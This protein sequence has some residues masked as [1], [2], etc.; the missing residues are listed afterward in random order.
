MLYLDWYYLVLV[1]PMI[2]VSLIAQSSV[3][4]NY[5]RFSKIANS[6]GLTGFEAAQRVLSYYGITNVRIEPV[7]GE[8]SDH[9]D[10]RSN[11]IRLSEGV[12]NT[13]SVSAV[14]IA[15]HEAGHASQHA[16][17][18]TPIKI[19]DSII[20]VCNIG[21]KLGIPLALAGYVFGFEPL[22]IIGILLYSLVFV[23]QLITLP[24]EF[25]ASSRALAVIEETG[26]LS[27]NEHKGAKKV[28]KAA[29]MTYVADAAT[30]L[31]NILRLILRM[32]RRS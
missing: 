3:K 2:I 17:G 22:I 1:V 24:V 15:C 13:A 11:V 31:A 14:C 8:L 5:R 16:E 20:P 29:A 6:K 32:R 9:F 27:E 18:Y 19:R 25:N 10:P 26:M 7:A 23:F 4:S 28:L 30:T 12:F 21:S